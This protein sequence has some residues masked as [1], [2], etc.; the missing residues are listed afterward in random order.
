MKLII[1]LILFPIVSLAWQTTIWHWRE[2]AGG[3]LSN[4]YRQ[5]RVP[6][7]I[8][9]ARHP[10]IIENQNKLE[11]LP[12]AEA[13]LCFSSR[14]AKTGIMGDKLSE[15]ENG[16]EI[17]S[18]LFDYLEIDNS[19]WGVD[20]PGWPNA[21]IRAQEILRCP[22]AVTQVKTFQASIYVYEG[23]YS[24]WILEPRQ[25]P[26]E[27]PGLFAD[28]LGNMTSLETLKWSIPPAYVHYF[29]ERFFDRGLVLPSIKRLELGRLSHFLVQL[30]SNITV[31]EYRGGMTSRDDIS[32]SEDP[33]SLLIR[34][35]MFA[36]K[37]KRFAMRPSWGWTDLMVQELVSGYMP[38]V[39]SLGLWG[40]MN[41][42]YEFIAN[43]N[44]NGSAFK[45]I[46]QLL[47]SLQNLTHLDLPSASELGV[48][49]DG[50]PFCGNAF[51]GP[52]GREYQ[53]QVY[54]EGVE[55]AERA[56]ALVLD[57]LP[58]LTSFSVGS[59]QANITRY[60]NGTLRA[61]FPW[62][63]RMDEWVGDVL[64]PRDVWP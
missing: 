14:E 9:D 46:L 12:D 26:R 1:V 39:E 55:A 48:G 62:S 54:Q 15:G 23:E 24:N 38:G 6:Q 4:P 21:L 45:E 17:P 32:G 50:G 47:S 11:S 33:E 52:R 51:E 30:G 16:L 60:E 7:F 2:K 43:E 13:Y 37:L 28:L 36:P 63:G 18:D 25:P 3:F 20:R 22:A 27:V 34:A 61:C 31:L 19:R 57:V 53:R 64:P 44:S 56:A 49:W 40:G 35:T 42:R 29:E 10:W 58:H 41:A 5:S 8:L 59:I